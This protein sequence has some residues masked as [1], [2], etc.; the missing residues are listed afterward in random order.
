MNWETLLSGAVGAGLFA[1]ALKLIEIYST[2]N[3]IKAE[4]TDTVVDTMLEAMQ[5]LRNERSEYL[6]R[7]KSL[8]DAQKENDQLI[9]ELQQH[10]QER[11][12]QIDE[13]TQNNEALLSQ[14]A[15]LRAQIAKDTAETRE[16][17]KQIDEIQQKYKKQL[18]INA[19]L[20][21]AL[22]DAKIP[23]PDFNGDL[24]DSIRGVKWDK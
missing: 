7:I 10:R 12:K 19:K 1:T 2:R 11:T 23:L 4:A 21:K 5:F 6:P 9:R 20:V 13:L 15:A 16:L 24:G 17:K 3:K 18:R 22:E 8:E 14:V